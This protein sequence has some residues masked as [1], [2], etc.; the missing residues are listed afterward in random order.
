VQPDSPLER[1]RKESVV[2]RQ[3]EQH[4]TGEESM[5]TT[6]VAAGDGGWTGVRATIVGGLA[7]FVALGLVANIPGEGPV[8][9][10]LH[11]VSSI[12]LTVAAALL[13][14]REARRGADLVAAG[15]AILTVAQVVMWAGFGTGSEASFA[16]AVLFFAPALFLISLPPR[17]PFWARIAG[18]LA[19]IPF[20]AHGIAYLLNGS[21]PEGLLH[22][23]GNIAYPVLI[24]AVIGWAV[25]AFRSTRAARKEGS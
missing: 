24:I 25:D 6:S 23:E 16:A 11:A 19:V 9:D 22:A 7:V 4:Q 21:Q 17:F 12:G 2:E 1:S 20:G 10:L 14:L 15:F 5:T 18:A 3:A 13:A 8:Q